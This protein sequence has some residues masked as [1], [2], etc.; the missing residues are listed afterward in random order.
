MARMAT[1]FST[2]TTTASKRASNP[3]A[4]TALL[5]STDPLT[6][7]STASA[8][9]R[10]TTGTKLPVKNLAVRR[11]TPSTAGPIAPRTAA[12]PMKTVKASPS[13]TVTSWRAE[14]ANRES[15][16]PGRL[17]DQPQRRR[18]DQEGHDP[19][20]HGDRHAGDSGHQQGVEEATRR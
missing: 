8:I 20:L 19:T 3:K 13:P 1:I 15:G 12:T 17:G 5:T 9:I 16:K 6:T 18:D 14:P 7:T 11:A 4:P 2:G 10:P